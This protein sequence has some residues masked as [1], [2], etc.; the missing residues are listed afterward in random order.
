MNIPNF[1]SDNCPKATE[2]FAGLFPTLLYIMGGL[3]L[4]AGPWFAQTAGVL[5]GA[6][7]DHVFVGKWLNGDTL[8]DPL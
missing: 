7:G 5:G 6:L 8:T 4:V 2:F 3:V 1:A